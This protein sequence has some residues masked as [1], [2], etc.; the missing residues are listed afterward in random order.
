V[1]TSGIKLFAVFLITLMAQLVLLKHLPASARTCDLVL[2]FL[3]ALAVSRHTGLVLVYALAAGMLT[4]SLSISYPLMHTIFYP[5][6]AVLLSLRRP[7]IYLSH[8]SLFAV[9]VAGLIVG[10][11]VFAYVWTL[12]FVQPISPVMLFR[13]SPSGIVVLLILAQLEGTGGA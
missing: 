5:G 1:R 2:L 9:T 12:V 6:A 10:K 11:I 7:Y 8:T 3:A 13:V 4:D